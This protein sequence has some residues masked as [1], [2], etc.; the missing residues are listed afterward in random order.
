MDL[1]FLMIFEDF[2]IFFEI[3]RILPKYPQ[4]YRNKLSCGQICIFSRFSLSLSNLVPGVLEIQW[5]LVVRDFRRIWK[6]FGNIHN[7]ENTEKLIWTQNC[8]FS[9]FS[10]SLSI[11]VAGVLEIHIC[12]FVP[13]FRR[14]LVIFVRILS[15]AQV[16]S[17]IQ[18]KWISDQKW[19]FQILSESLKPSTWNT[20]NSEISKF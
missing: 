14:C 1:Y 3:F 19:I 4:K 6:L 2:G 5:F 15:F 8:M 9:R 20:R 12:V 10:L 18:K 7:F 11:L 17:Q 13:G 16:L